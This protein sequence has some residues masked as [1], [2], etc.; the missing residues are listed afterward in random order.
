MQTLLDLAADYGGHVNVVLLALVFIP[1]ATVSFFLMRTVRAHG[2]VKRRA[3]GITSD[4]LMSSGDSRSLRHTSLRAAQ[5]LIDRTTKHYSADDKEVRMLRQRLVQAGVFDPR[6]VG[7]FFL[8][9][10]MLAV[11]MAA[12]AFVLTPVLTTHQNLLWI[13]V[14]VGGLL[15]YLGPSVALDRIVA[16]RSQEYRAGFP[17]M[18]D[19]L[20]VGADAGL[21]LASAFERVGRELADSYPNLS[22]NI[23]MANLEIRAG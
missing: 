2:S 16:M 9:R 17:D 12:A 15:G 19:L 20:L 8:A 14:G 7:F 1:T 23:H 4:M 22:A 11:A 13:F 18:M 6:A 21:G 5:R 3:S 10:G